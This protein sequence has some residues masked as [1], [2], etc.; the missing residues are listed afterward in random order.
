MYEC[1]CNPGFVLSDN[2]YS[3]I[4]KLIS[5]S[6]SLAIFA[7]RSHFWHFSQIQ[8][9]SEVPIILVLPQERGIGNKTR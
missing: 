4:G 6:A 1:D 3:C 2:G 5:Q 7:L 8:S 9:Y